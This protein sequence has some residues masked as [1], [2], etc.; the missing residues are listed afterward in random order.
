M[1]FSHGNVEVDEEGRAT[2]NGSAL[3]LFELLVAQHTDASK[4]GRPFADPHS[5]PDDTFDD[6]EGKERWR[7]AVLKGNVARLRDYARTANAIAEWLHEL[8]P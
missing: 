4:G 7:V 1:V 3:R 5:P 6:A 8:L 2:G